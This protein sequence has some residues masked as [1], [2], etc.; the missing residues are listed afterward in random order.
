[1]LEADFGKGPAALP[2]FLGKFRLAQDGLGLGQP[3]IVESGDVAQPG[4]AAKDPWS[5][6]WQLLGIF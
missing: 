1:M 4:E 2:L 5:V 3:G 6:R